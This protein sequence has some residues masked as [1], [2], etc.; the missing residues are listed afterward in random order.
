MQPSSQPCNTVAFYEFGAFRLDP[1]RRLLLDAGGRRIALKP[2]A[3]D[4]LLCFV[5]N[6]GRLLDK[7]TLIKS[8]WGNVIVDENG[9][10]Q[11]VSKLRKVLGERPGENR[12]IVTIPG[13][14]YCFVA[15]VRPLNAD[16]GDASGEDNWRFVGGPLQVST[17]SDRDV[18]LSRLV[19]TRRERVFETWTKPE[20]LRRWY[21]LPGWS[22]A[23]CELELRQG[24]T[25]RFVTR[26]A[27]GTEVVQRGVF[28]EVTPPERLVHTEHWDNAYVPEVLVTTTFLPAGERTVLKVHARHSTKHSRDAFL[29]SGLTR[30]IGVLYD[31]FAQLAETGSL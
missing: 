22:M 4:T 2:K 17:P 25:M 20:L 26:H 28:R 21:A 9:L 13:R 1:I 3:F 27:D 12:F 16:A 24:G 29:E 23:V 14:G 7:P 11:H 5:R 19:A 31:R 10:S 8:V 6:Q 18:V 30:D 15:E